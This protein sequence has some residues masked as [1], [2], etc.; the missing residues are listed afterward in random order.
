MK[1]FLSRTS[2]FPLLA[3]LII[4]LIG[5]SACSS[6]GNTGRLSI[7]LTDKPTND[8]QSVFVTIEDIAVHAAGDAEGTW[9]TILHVHQTFDLTT[10]SNGVRKELGIVNLDPGH[11]TQMRLILGQEAIMPHEFANYVVDRDGVAHSMKIPSGMQTGIK[12]IQGFDINENST[13]ELVFDF[14]ASRSVVVAGNS[15][16]FLLKPTIHMIDDNQTRTIIKGTVKTMEDAALEGANVS[17]QVYTPMS[18]PPAAG[19]DLKDEVTVWTSTLTDAAGAYMF[20]FLDVPDPTTFN[21]VATDWAST[22]QKDYVPDWGQIP[23]AVNGNVYPVDFTLPVPAEVGTLGLKAIVVDADT[24]KNPDPE[25]VVTISIRQISDLTGAP[26]VEVKSV[27]IV[28]Y[29]DEYLLTEITAVDV[30][31]PAGTYTVVASTPGRTSVEKT[32]TVTKAGPNALDFQFDL[33]L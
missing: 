21:L 16:K 11:Y 33:P 28:G 25:T 4:G 6:G 30:K 31:L 2:D 5:L 19:Q 3:V 9:N 15:G 20:W 26:L 14:D 10:L 1:S 23:N 29:D 32:I 8:F 22:D 27:P 24:A 18:R 13:T 12:I 7:S 17:L